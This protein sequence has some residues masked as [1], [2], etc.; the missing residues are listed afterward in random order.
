MP[1]TQ[2]QVMRYQ[3]QQGD[4]RLVPAGQGQTDDRGVFRVW[5]LNPGEYYVS[6]TA[7]NEG[8]G[9]GVDP[10]Q[11]QQIVQDA[12]AAAG[13]GAAPGRGGRGN[14][15]AAVAFGGIPAE[16]QEQLMYAPTYYPGVDSPAEA[17]AVTVGVSAEVTDVDFGLHLV[18]TARVSGRVQNPDGSAPVQGNVQL[19]PQGGAR[20]NFGQTFGG[21]IAADGVFSIANVPP[22]SYT[23]RARNNDR[24]AP[25]TTSQPVS[26][27]G[28]DI[29]NLL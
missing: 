1:G 20:G 5:G 14:G 17:R 12:I 10:V 3:Y 2:V 7:R 11:I 24:N 4:R 9:R 23:L 19:S 27:S 22:G 13:R 29:N 18:R 15:V 16:D 8:L 28:G 21:R 25:L 26:V 6:A